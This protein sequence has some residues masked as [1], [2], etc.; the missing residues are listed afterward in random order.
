VA[1]RTPVVEG[2]DGLFLALDRRTAAAL[3][4]HLAAG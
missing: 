3:F 1:T 2:S 4:P